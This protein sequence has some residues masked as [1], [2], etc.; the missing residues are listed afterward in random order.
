MHLAGYLPEVEANDYLLAGY[1]TVC[2]AGIAWAL[3]HEGD[4]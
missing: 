1:L 2:V 4:E 3:F